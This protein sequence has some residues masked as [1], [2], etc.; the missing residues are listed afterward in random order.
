MKQLSNVTE[1]VAPREVTVVRCTRLLCDICGKEAERPETHRFHYA[2]DGFSTNTLVWMWVD[3]ET[4][5]DG[6]SV[7]DLCLECAQALERAI[8]DPAKRRKLV[9]VI[10]AKAMT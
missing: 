10:Q 2:E 7:T 4:R 1:G 3:R 9:A 6:Q 8:K 5:T